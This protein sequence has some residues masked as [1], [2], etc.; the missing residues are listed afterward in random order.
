MLEFKNP[1]EN[2]KL[3]RKLKVLDVERNP[4]GEL[5]KLYVGD[6]ILEDDTTENL[7]QLN[8]EN[9][10]KIITTM[11]HKEYLPPYGVAQLILLE[12]I[13]QIKPIYTSNEDLPVTNVAFCNWELA[14]DY[15]GAVLV[16][17]NRLVFNREIYDIEFELQIEV[18]Y[19]DVHLYKTVK[20]TLKGLGAN[21]FTNPEDV[22]YE[23]VK[24]IPSYLEK[25]YKL[26]VLE[27]AT[28]SLVGDEDDAVI[29]DNLLKIIKQKSVGDNRITLRVEYVKGVSVASAEMYIT[30]GRLYLFDNAY[31]NKIKG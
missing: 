28:W 29:E 30:I 25:D 1:E 4:N 12:L 17:G 5:R 26:P 20:S 6:T 21:S 10:E 8:K 15:Q 18:I 13:N 31:T 23:L 22:V 24:N 16:Q 9:L 11:I 27:N 2:I 3:K 7:I 14:G 19:E